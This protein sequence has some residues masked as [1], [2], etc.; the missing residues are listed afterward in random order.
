LLPKGKHGKFWEIGEL[1]D[2]TTCSGPAGPKGDA[3]GAAGSERLGKAGAFCLLCRRSGQSGQIP[4]ALAGTIRHNQ[5]HQFRCVSTGPFEAPA[6][7]T[8]TM[9]TFGKVLAFLNVFAVIGVVALLAMDY[10]KRRSWEYA[11]FRQDLLMNGLPLDDQERDNQ[12]QLLVANVGPQ[13]QKDL[14]AG[15]APVATQSEEVNRVKGLLQNKISAAGDNRNAKLVA[16]AHILMPFAITNEER[17]RLLVYQ[18]YLRDDN[19]YKSL[20]QQF[21]RADQTARQPAAAGKKAPSYDEAFRQALAAQQAYPLLPLADAYLAVHKAAPGTTADKAL[22]QTLD[23]HLGQLQGQFDGLFQDALTQKDGSN[24]RPAAQRKRSIARVLFNAVPSLEEQPAGGAAPKT[25]LLENS[26]YRRFINVVGVRSA[27]AAVNDEA[28]V[29]DTIA[30][31]VAQERER[32]RGIFALEHAKVIRII[33][34]KAGEV[35]AH[36]QQL[37]SKQKELAAHEEDLKKRRLDIKFY[38]DQLDAARKETLAHLEQLQK[39]SDALFKMRVDLRE[40]TATNQK[41]EKTIRD[42]EAGH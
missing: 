12:G 21:Q 29:L 9:S 1:P 20:Q 5:L 23:T 15:N 31:Q 40:A 38:T 22:E 18:S 13:T 11:V 27:I 42:L 7:G 35:E 41:L 16:L 14:F 30:V 24:Q 34:E 39:M 36:N 3:G 19:A 4:L 25:D 28:A 10:A 6:Q 26:L 37:A 32:W 2:F 33:E 17:Q 8:A